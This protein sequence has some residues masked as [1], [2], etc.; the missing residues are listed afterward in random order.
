M[1]AAE[2]GTRRSRKTRRIIS[3]L[4]E[5]EKELRDTDPARAIHF[6]ELAEQLSTV[7]DDGW[8]DSLDWRALLAEADTELMYVEL[9][10]ERA[11]AAGGAKA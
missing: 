11:A 2:R 10:A 5:A 1:T 7:C 6:I 3:L 4:Y 8:S 9:E